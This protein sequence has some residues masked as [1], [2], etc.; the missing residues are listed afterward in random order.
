MGRPNIKD[1]P[2]FQEGVALYE[3]IKSIVDDAKAEADLIV[4]SA[5]RKTEEKTLALVAYLK[6]RELSNYGIGLITGVTRHDLLTDLVERARL[7]SG[8]GVKPIDD[9]SVDVLGWKWGPPVEGGWTPFVDPDGNVYTIGWDE[10][11]RIEWR[12]PDGTTMTFDERDELPR[13]VEMY[14]AENLP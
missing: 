4:K 10:N 2:V 3:P 7:Y 8:E 11:T 14:A 5:R 12:Y 1:N 6:K 9:G 13:E